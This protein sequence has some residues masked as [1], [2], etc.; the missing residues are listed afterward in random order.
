MGFGLSYPKLPFLEWPEVMPY[1]EWKIN[2]GIIN[3]KSNR[4]PYVYWEDAA[5]I[6][7]PP[8]RPPKAQIQCYALAVD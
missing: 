3:K 5:T 1:M 8:K 4:R 7:P 6:D 2:I